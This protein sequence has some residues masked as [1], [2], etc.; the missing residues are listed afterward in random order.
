MVV[1][2]L[3]MIFAF[4]LIAVTT[5]VMTILAMLLMRC[6]LGLGPSFEVHASSFLDEEAHASSAIS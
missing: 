1:F 6:L 2:M 3:S 5:V 4:A